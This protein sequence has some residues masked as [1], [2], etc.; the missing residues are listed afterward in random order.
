MSTQEVHWKILFVLTPEFHPN[1][2]GVQMTTFKLARWFSDA[3]HEVAVFSFAAEGHISQSF[4]R[5]VAGPASGGVSESENL[6]A[7]EAMVKE[8]DPDVAATAVNVLR[9]VRE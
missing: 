2:G 9:A 6:I 4:A 5:L 8:F 1:N 7:L 3:S